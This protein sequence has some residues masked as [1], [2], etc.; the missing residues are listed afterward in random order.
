M[1]NVY[2]SNICTDC[3]FYFCLLIIRYVMQFD[4]KHYVPICDTSRFVGKL[5]LTVG[6]TDGEIF[7]SIRNPYRV[8]YNHIETYDV[9]GIHYIYISIYEEGIDSC[10]K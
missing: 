2:I 5:F 9:L 8:Y 10:V 7:V 3:L 1:A 6:P 4:S